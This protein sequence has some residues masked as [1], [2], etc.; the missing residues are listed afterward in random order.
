MRMK[1]GDGGFRRVPSTRE[2]DD[3][4]AYIIED[5]IGDTFVAVDRPRRTMPRRVRNSK[6]A[7]RHVP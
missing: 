1:L 3:W 4:R 7:K 6:G 2:P 5:V